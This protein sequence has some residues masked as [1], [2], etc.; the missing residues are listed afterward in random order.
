MSSMAHL[1]VIDGTKKAK[2][3]YYALYSNVF[4][5]ELQVATDKYKSAAEYDKDTL[6][7]LIWSGVKMI[8]ASESRSNNKEGLENKF[9]LVTFINSLMAQL[10]PREFQNIFPI[11]KEFDGERWEVKDYFYTR[12]YI[13]KF[14]EDKVIG[15]DMDEF[16][17]EYQNWTISFYMLEMMGITSDL[18]Q[19]ETGKSIMEE[20]LEEQGVPTYT[21]HDNVNGKQYI[22]NNQ[23]GEVTEIKKPRPRYLRVVENEK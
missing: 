4:I 2:P 23:T 9:S 10:T 22:E 1:K 13:E 7:K 18:R 12:K 11:N 16:L 8:I 5:N 21:M 15:E 20:F 14:G 6:K 3:D 17:W 19:L